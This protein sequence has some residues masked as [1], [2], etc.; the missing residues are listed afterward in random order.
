VYYNFVAK[1]GTDSFHGGAAY[2]FENSGLVSDNVTDALRDQGIRT[3]AGI[4]LFSDA[5]FQ[6]GGPL[7]KDKVRF[8]TS[9]RDWRIHRDVPNFSKSENTDLFSGL[10]NLSYQVNP[11]NRLDVLGT[12]Q[13]YYKPNRNASAQVPP[14]TTWIEDDVF[15][16]FQSHYNSQISQNALFDVR[17]SYSNIDFPL[18][19][20]DGVTRQNTTEETT[21]N[22]TGVSPQ[23]FVFYRSR[24]AGDATMT[25]FKSQ[26]LGA[27][28]EFRLGYQLG[29]AFSES[30]T[31][32]VD[33]VTL[34]TFEGAASNLIAWN[35]PVV[36]QSRYTDHVLFFQ[37]TVTK[38]R[39]VLDLGLRYQYTKGSLPA[40]SSPA[41]PFAPA[42]NFA[43]QDVISWSDLAPRLGLIFDIRG[44]HKSA[45]K[46]GYGR[47]YHQL[48][49]EPIEAQS[50]NALGGTGY[51]WIDRNGDLQF[52]PGELGDLLFA[53]GGSSIT[54]VDPDLKRP[55][56]DEVSAGFEF[57]LPKN[58]TLSID[59]LLRWGSQLVATT[60][61]GIPFDT[62]YTTTTAVEPGADGQPGTGDDQRVAVFNLRPE[63]AGANRPFVT[64]PEGFET[65]YRG[66]EVT[67]QKRFSD[68]WQG[69][70]GYSISKDD[71][72]RA[73]VGFSQFGGGE[74]E[75]AGAGTNGGFTD[76][77]QAINNTEG[78]SFFDRRHSFKLSG[79]Y[80]VPRIDVN[81]A[82]VV[83]I[84][85]GVPSPRLATVSED[86]NGVAFNQGPITFFAEPRGSSRIE[87]LKYADFRIAKFFNIRQSQR[88]EVMVDVFN[89]FNANAVTTVNNNT[90]SD[91]GNALTILGPRVV[92]FGAR[93]TF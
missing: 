70:L 82:A 81:I 66:V 48:N 1:R 29:R 56:T 86:V 20:Q 42:R 44:D 93:Y 26:L 40:Q 21:G 59:G 3:G 50:Q 35:T 52:Q 92:R 23:Q 89:L 61:A 24:L 75:S 76:P 64:N 30:D 45:F 28:H 63:F 47:Y 32:V 14:D 27:A 11:K 58:I 55:R 38:G 68:R 18:F 2:Y 13:T 7:V 53:F 34:N 69:L 87:T 90:G 54:T 15:R 65:N 10:V 36:T 25:L 6:L 5:T 33:G 43:E 67:L 73:G 88:F 37:D 46:L 41:G 80:Q 22:Q 91:L 19:F 57:Q 74:E 31:D 79:S 85:T 78:A 16:I 60:E 17:I 51:N 4:N 72:S 9:W 71:L 12:I 8:F 39:V 83:K 77:N 62:G 84:Q 49:P